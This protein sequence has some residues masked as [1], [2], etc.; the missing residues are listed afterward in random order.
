MVA[1][2]QQESGGAQSPNISSGGDVSVRYVDSEKFKYTVLI[3]FFVF[4]ILLAAVLFF[5]RLGETQQLTVSLGGNS[6]SVAPSIVETRAVEPETLNR[7][8][9][10]VDVDGGFYYELPPGDKWSTPTQV[11]GIMNVIAEKKAVL[12]EET[13]VNL[14][15]NLSI[16]PLGLMLADQ[17]MTRIVTGDPIR[18]EFTPDTT[19]NVA[20]AVINNILE[21][22]SQ[23]DGFSPSEQEMIQLR[24]SIYKDVL[25]FERMDFS[26]EFTVTTLDKALLDKNLESSLQIFAITTLAPLGFFLEKLVADE[27]S[28]L[29]GMRV[30][31]R[32]VLVDGE[33]ESFDVYRWIYIAESKDKFHVVEIAWSPQTANSVSTWDDLKHLLNSFRILR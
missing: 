17:E 22:A 14:Q 24:E 23:E 19:N 2:N 5:P 4:I 3:L 31:L 21:I 33:T 9:Y 29:A 10:F 30:S 15:N 1:G 28:I 13:E 12:N 18:I 7:A 6:L 32:N 27:N 20:E 25:M 16:H 11:S 8:N 26:N